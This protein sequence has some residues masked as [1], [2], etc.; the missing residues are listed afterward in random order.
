[1]IQPLKNKLVIDF[2][3]FLSGPSCTL[4]LADL[5]AEVIK[6][7]RPLTG[8]ICR[9]LYVS[10]VMIDGESSLF[11]AINRNK[12]SFV[13]DLKNETDLASIKKLIAVADV[14][15]H[16]FRPGVMKRLGLDYDDVKTIQPT[17]IYASIS[18]YGYEG[19]LANEPGQ[20]LLLQAVSGLSWLSGNEEDGPVP[21]GAS[22]V[23]TLAGTYL[24]QGILAALFKKNKTGLGSSVQVSMLESSLDFQFEVFTSYLN[25]GNELPKRSAVNAANAYLSAPYG[26]YKTSN[27]FIALAMGSIPIIADLIDCTELLPFTTPAEWF[28]KRDSIKRIL[29]NHLQKNT[30]AWWLNKL[31]PADIWCAEVLNYETLR[32]HDGYKIL[33]MEQEIETSAGTV[34]TTTRCP[35]KINGVV[36][37]YIDGAPALGEHNNLLT[38][39]FGL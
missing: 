30:T 26:I 20:D 22:V 3:Q 31:E 21:M 18:G 25:D 27:G 24:A 13:A 19:E 8:D 9:Q 33:D 38:E 1:M 28:S 6:I 11:H 23:D 15:V 10:N 17:I 32:N 39:Q 14:L 4:R 2:S 36:L 7:E 5:G 34:I 37:K 29:A 16:N 35:I 12:K